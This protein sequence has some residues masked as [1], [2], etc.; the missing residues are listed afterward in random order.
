MRADLLLN[1][2]SDGGG[3]GSGLDGAAYFEAGCSVARMACKD[4]VAQVRWV[5]GGVHVCCVD[6][7]SQAVLS[8]RLLRMSVLCCC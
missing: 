4:R 3:R 1:S 5:F 2:L 7:T 6:A 8:V